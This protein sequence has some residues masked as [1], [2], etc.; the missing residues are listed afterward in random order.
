MRALAFIAAIAACLAVLT[1]AAGAQTRL[2]NIQLV[3]KQLSLRTTD[4]PPK[5]ASVGD[6]GRAESRLLNAV[7]QWG[8][9]AGARVGR[10]VATYT[11][12]ASDI[13]LMQGVT[14]LPGGT[15]VVRGP[16][17]PDAGGG[18]LV[19]VVRGTGRYVGARGSLRIIR[20]TNPARTLN[21]YRLRYRRA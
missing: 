8:K 13:V 5:G 11:F 21:V 2:T 6:V 4:R 1:A 18:I 7:R 3:T 16:M 12:T 19:P 14:Y 15:L 17:E 9:P 20:E 10:E